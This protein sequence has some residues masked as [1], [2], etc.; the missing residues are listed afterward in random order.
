MAKKK[1]GAAKKR[2]GKKEMKKTKG[3]LG[4]IGV[5]AVC[6]SPGS[7]KNMTVNCG[8]AMTSVCGGSVSGGCVS[9]GCGTLQ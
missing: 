5:T 9:G 7:V 6:Q 8:G 4:S 1:E 2:L 3:G